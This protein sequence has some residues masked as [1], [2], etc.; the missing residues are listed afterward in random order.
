MADE[1]PTVKW[2][3]GGYFDAVGFREENM[4]KNKTAVSG[5]RYGT[6]A[7]PYG[8]VGPV[9]ASDGGSRDGRSIDGVGHL[10]VHIAPAQ[11]AGCRRVGCYCQSQAD[12]GTVRPRGAAS[13]ILWGGHSR[14]ATAR[15]HQQAK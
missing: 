6:G 12:G 7:Q 2:M 1:I 5:G 11:V 14:R 8:M 10:A 9:R 13:N 3:A 15:D 4:R